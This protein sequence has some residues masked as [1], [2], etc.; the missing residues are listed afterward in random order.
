MGDIHS[1]WAGNLNYQASEVLKPTTVKEVQE[2]I[3][4]ASSVKALGS[5][6]C[7][8]DIA[9]STGTQILTGNLNR[10]IDID[11]E[12]L[13]ITIESG[14]QYGQF[15][16]ELNEKGYALHNLASL[17]HISVVGAAATATHGS[18]IHNQNLAGSII[19]LEF[20]TGKG[21]IVNL[22]R[23]SDGDLFSGV[24]V[25]LGALGVVTKAKLKLEKAFSVRQDCF[26]DLPFE[27]LA[28]NFTSIL[29]AGYSVSLFTTWRMPIV[30]QVWI[31]SRVDRFLDLGDS[32]YGAKKSTTDFHPI[33]GISAENCTPQQGV[34]GPWCDRLSHFKMGFMPSAG[35]ELQSEYFVA[36]KDAVEA[37]WALNMIRESIS[38][39]L[40]I[41]EI[42]TIAAD[43]F[44]LSPAYQQDSVAFHFTWKQDV[45]AVLKLLPAIESA[46]EPFGVRPHWGKFFTISKEKIRLLYPKLPDFEKL[47]KEFDPSEKF[48]NDYLRKNIISN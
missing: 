44:W 25:N 13:T 17:P 6:H 4:N 9:D 24:V 34:E 26:A 32:F 46:L 38:P 12:S 30:E 42:R 7:F 5:R 14:L 19:G 10:I 16:P 29:S 40:M 15:C 48:H 1:N 21:E 36:H 39:L 35:E 27:N 8:N 33:P 43:D 2:I 11:E 37:L 41:S 20:V 28:R 47:M 23:E 18:G 31:K 3:M 45:S 22:T